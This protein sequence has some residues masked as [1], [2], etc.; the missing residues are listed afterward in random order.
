MTRKI[1]CEDLEVLKDKRLENPRKKH[2][3]IPL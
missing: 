1:I 2:C 3:N